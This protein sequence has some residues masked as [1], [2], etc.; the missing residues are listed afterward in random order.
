[1]PSRSKVAGE[2]VREFIQRQAGTSLT[3]AS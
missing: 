1:V 3:D 2:F